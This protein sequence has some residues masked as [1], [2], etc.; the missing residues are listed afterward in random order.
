MIIEWLLDFV[1]GGFNLIVGLFPQ[2]TFN[3][4]ASLQSAF[5]ALGGLNY[6]LPIGE[7]VNAVVAFLVLGAPFMLAS[8]VVWIVSFIRGSS[9]RG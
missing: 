6:F 8:I 3:P 7:M 5:P 9:A 2:T 1:E 4:V